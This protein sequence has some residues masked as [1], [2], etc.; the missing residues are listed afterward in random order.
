MKRLSLL[1]LATLMSCSG[2]IKNS[3]NKSTSNDYKLYYNVSL[4]FDDTTN[5]FTVYT[6]GDYKESY[7]IKPWHNFDFITYDRM[8]TDENNNHIYNKFY[9]LSSTHYRYIVGK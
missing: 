3:D 7:T 1:V 2:N 9:V 4:R 8:L 5:D 6:T